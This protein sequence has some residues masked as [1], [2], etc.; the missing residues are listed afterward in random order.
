MKYLKTILVLLAAVQGALGQSVKWE[1]FIQPDRAG[2]P[3]VA[4]GRVWIPTTAGLVEY[5]PASAIVELHN[6]A[7]AGLVSN[8]IE[9]VAQHPFTNDLYI[10]TYDLALMVRPSGTTTWEHLPY[11]ASFYNGQGEAPQTYCMAFDEEG[12]LW[13]GTNIGLLS[14]DNGTWAQ[15]EYD[16]NAFYGAVWDLDFSQEGDLLIASHGA[17]RKEGEELVLLSPEDGSNGEPLFAYGGS[18]IHQAEDG[19]I[20][21]F[22][23]IGTVGAYDGESWNHV[24]Q[25]PQLSIFG[26]FISVVEPAPGQLRILVPARAQFFLGRSG[27]DRRRGI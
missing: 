25:V 21:F 10:G 4:N 27:M 2:E 6:K 15:L 24:E 20:W 1:S 22:T 17:F 5:E 3:V 18:V 8:S 23:D 19:Q 13:V 12:V 7:T 14:Y 26:A 11:P 9:A 16:E